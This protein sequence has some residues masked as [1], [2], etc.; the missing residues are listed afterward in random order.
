MER[1]INVEIKR[2]V[3][4]RLK[5]RAAKEEKSISELIALLLKQ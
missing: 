2:D 4:K 3:H 1:G 5:I